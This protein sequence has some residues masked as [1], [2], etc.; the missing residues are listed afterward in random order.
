MEVKCSEGAWPFSVLAAAATSAARK[1]FQRLSHLLTSGSAL[2][3]SAHILGDAST[4]KDR[5]V[6]YITSQSPS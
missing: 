5:A 4:A 3:D 1:R 2:W 6:T